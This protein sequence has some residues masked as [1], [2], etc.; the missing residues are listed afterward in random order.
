MLGSSLRRLWA[1][2]GAIL[3]ILGGLH[4]VS[5]RAVLEDSII[6]AMA[7]GIGIVSL[8]LAGLTL[9]YGFADIRSGK[10]TSCPAC[11]ESILAAAT[12]CPRCTTELDNCPECER[13]IREADMTCPYCEAELEYVPKDQAEPVT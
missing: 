10:L 6:Q 7:N 1:L 2:I 5:I 4:L 13:I 8:G 12:R 11:K 3:L 9:A